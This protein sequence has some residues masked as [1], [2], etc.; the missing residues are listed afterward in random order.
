MDMFDYKLL[1]ALAAVVEQGGFE[2][3]A[4]VLGLS[5]SAV[6]QRVKLLEARVGQPVL[7][8][9]AP[10]A[11]TEIGTRLLNHVQQVRLLERDLQAQ[12]PALDEGGLP[13]RLRIAINADSLAT[14]WAPAVADYCSSHHVLMDLV[15]EDQE[16]GLKR[17]RAGEVA[18]CICAAERPVA[19]ARS[20]AL[21][22]MRYRALASPG[23]VARHFSRGVTAE[24]LLNAPSIV[25]GP[26]D[27]LQHR[28]LAALG[29]QGAF[30]HHLC[31][32]SEGFVRLTQA[33]LGWG[34]VPEHQVEG[35]LARGELVELIPQR[36]IDVPLYW[37]HWRH[38]GELLASLTDHLAWAG[39]RWLVRD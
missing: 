23:F 26:D 38:G 37:H 10:P 15:V 11:P 7:V 19:G 13:E 16:V 21:G 24:A 31:P 33:G 36:P 22:A 9:A 2:R 25:Y 12:V 29:I 5:Q 4:Q 3:A 17:M 30:P 20:L 32:S 39:G 6:S 35:E 8:R 14:W 34:L 18:G 27:Q 28:Y 1:A